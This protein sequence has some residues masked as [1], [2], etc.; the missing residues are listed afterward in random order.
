MATNDALS[1]KTIGEEHWED[2]E[3]EI[4]NSIT[5]PTPHHPWI[6]PLYQWTYPEAMLQPTGKGEEAKEDG[7]KEGTKEG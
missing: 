1:L 5:P 6:T 3:E 4:D 7:T 2:K